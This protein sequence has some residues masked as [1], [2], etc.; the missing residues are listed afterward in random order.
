[1]GGTGSGRWRNHRRATLVEKALGLDLLNPRWKEALSQ[2]RA[3]GSL[4]WTAP[5]SAA[6][7]GRIDFHLAPVEPNGTR[8]V[9][10]DFTG[11]PCEPYQVVTLERAQVGFSERWY[12]RCPGEC[13]ERARKL[14][15]V[16][17]RLE[18]ACRR[19]AR[20]QYWSA[21]RH[22]SRLDLARRDPQGFVQIRAKAP[23]TLR[24]Q[25]V[26]SRFLWDAVEYPITH[27]RRGR[28]WSRKSYTSRHRAR[29]ELHRDFE[30]RWGF[31]LP[32]IRPEQ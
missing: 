14:Y 9:A 20:L 30:R 32:R 16:P 8:T 27:P 22:D 3:S 2:H 7:L 4:E 31:P 23:R 5:P 10:F 28:G 18:F 19:C 11:D 25:F 12:A 15:W 26:T 13:G 6:P 17:G 1:M 29:D 24:S 21:Q